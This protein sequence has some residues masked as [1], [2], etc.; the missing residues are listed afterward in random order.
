MV[1]RLAAACAALG[2]GLVPAA[3]AHAEIVSQK[4]I[5]GVE[6]GA[7]Q[8]EVRE[9]VGNPDRLVD[10]ENS[11][12]PYTEFRYPKMS[13]FFQDDA[14]ASA[15]R[16]TDPKEKTAKGI[17]VGSSASAVKKKVGGARCKLRG[18]KGTCT[19]GRNRRGRPRTIFTVRRGK[20]TAVELEQGLGKR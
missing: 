14:D 17:G 15:V 11:A 1:R 6:L 19:V 10:G 5:A 8:I 2:A 13:V 16:T 7:S 4:S 3:G 20:V 18:R 9:A 12:G